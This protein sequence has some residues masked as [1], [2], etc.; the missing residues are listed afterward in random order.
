MSLRETVRL[1]SI[2]SRRSA[3]RAPA[4]LGAS[5][6]R[7]SRLIRR[8]SEA[9][10]AT[11]TPPA[12]P[13][14]CREGSVEWMQA[15]GGGVWRHWRACRRRRDHGPSAWDRAATGAR[16]RAPESRVTSMWSADR[17]RWARASPARCTRNDG[18]PG[19]GCPPRSLISMSG[20][21]TGSAGATTPSDHDV[22]WVAVNEGRLHVAGTTLRRE[23][24]GLRGSATRLEFI[25]PTARPSWMLGSA[26]AKHAHPLVCG[27][28]S[29]HT[30]ATALIA[31]EAGIRRMSRA[32][33]RARRALTMAWAAPAGRSRPG[34]ER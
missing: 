14:S 3:C 1:F 29:V 8:S 2:S 22:A 28:Y 30:S 34:R 31:G 23:I 4:A 13:A 6:T 16:E 5:G 7:G 15:C 32:A 17:D 26:A 18:Q 9:A 20:C 11:R 19:R 24:G 12:N 21:R 10:S 25:S 33:T 27:S